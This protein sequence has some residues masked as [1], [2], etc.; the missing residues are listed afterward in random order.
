MESQARDEGENGYILGAIL[1]GKR[2]SVILRKYRLK[3]SGIDWHKLYYD[4][5]PLF[6][7]RYSPPMGSCNYAYYLIHPWMYFIE[8]Y[9]ET[10]WFVQRGLR[11]WADCDAWGWCRHL[12]RINV[13]VLTYLRKHVH[14]YPLGLT[15]RTWD[16]KLQ[17][18]IDGFQAM[19]DEEND[20]TSYKKFSHKDHL[21]LVRSRQR[22]LMLALKYF[23]LYYYNLWD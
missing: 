23:R 20:T 19:L 21:K 3:D 17:V 16:K 14:G 9:D 7:V 10:K 8:L 15:P 12:S 4:I 1:A 13:E 18:M 5:V 2:N 22:K 6:M 11:G